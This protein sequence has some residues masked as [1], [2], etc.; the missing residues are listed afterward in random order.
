MQTSDMSTAGLPA[1]PA[2][3]AVAAMAAAHAAAARTLADAAGF[4]LFG[5]FHLGGEE[6]ALPAL[7]IR[8]VVAYPARVTRMPLSP[9]CLE[10][11]FTLRG[12]AIPVVNLARVFDPDAPAAGAHQQVAILDHEEVLVGLVIDTTG[13]VLRV[14]PG[15]RSTVVHEGGRQSV[16]GGTIMLGDGA[17]LLQVLVPEALIRIDNVPQVRSMSTTMRAAERARFLRHAEARKCLCFSAGGSSFAF[18]MTA[19]QEIIAVPAL[20]TSVMTGPLC[21][22]WINFRGRAVGIV[23]FGALVGRP[24]DQAGQA[25]GAEDDRRILMARIGDELLGFLV[26]SVDTIIPYFDSDVLPIPLLGTRRGAMYRG[27]LPRPDGAGTLFLDH[28]RVLSD[29]ELAEVC[30]GHR[31][32]YQDEV[33]AEALQGAQAAAARKQVYLAF[34]L[35][36]AWATEIGQVCEIISTT[37]AITCPPDA[38]DCVR[39][40]L[41]LRRQMVSIIDLRRLYGMPPLDD[42]GECRIL[43]LERGAERYGVIVDRVDSIVHLPASAR[44]ASPKLLRAGGDIVDMRSSVSEVLELPDGTVMH[45][46]DR[47]AFLARLEAA[48]AA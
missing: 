18:A 32:I 39:G 1:D 28:A 4:E 15:Q 20:R 35:D 26:D 33:A 45:L 21:R 23:D 34:T 48:L 42:T 17:R 40:M 47:A 14:R 25:A 44:R 38:P 31:R 11:I 2:A 24:A 37:Q 12:V 6:F 36:S 41:N 22:G 29:A 10:G 46:F 19:V 27:C 5:S 3:R 8:E 9:G 16:V 43:V 7:A 30:A 13:E